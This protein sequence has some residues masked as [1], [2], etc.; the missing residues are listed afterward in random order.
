[1]YVSACTCPHH[2]L[3]HNIGARILMKLGKST[4][5]FLQRLA[6]AEVSMALNMQEPL[7]QGPRVPER[8]YFMSLSP[9]TSFLKPLRVEDV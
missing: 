8:W 3:K 7:E 1:M 2:T 4:F 5:G 6:H 9:E